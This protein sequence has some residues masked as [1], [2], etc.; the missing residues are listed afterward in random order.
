MGD[1]TSTDARAQRGAPRKSP[2]PDDPMELVAE[3]VPGDEE[4]A[5]RCLIEEYAAI[6]FDRDRILSLFRDEQYPM[7]HAEYRRRGERAAAVLVDEVLRECGV[8]R[9][10]DAYPEASGLGTTRVQIRVRPRPEED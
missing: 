6:G 9:F 5:L 8:G 10:R 4:Y 2:E 3:R 7:L 1:P